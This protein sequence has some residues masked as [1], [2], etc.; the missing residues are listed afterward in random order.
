VDTNPALVTAAEL[1]QIRVMAGLSVPDASE[2]VG[3]SRTTWWRWEKQGVTVPEKLT[4]VIR[5]LT[6]GR[7]TRQAIE[8]VT[9]I[10]IPIYNLAGTATSCK[11]FVLENITGQIG[12]DRIFIQSHLKADPDALV[13]MTIDGDSME[14]TVRSGEVAIL[15]RTTLAS[16]IV[17]GV[18]L[19]RLEGAILCRVPRCF[20]WVTG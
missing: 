11:D 20:R 6:A 3:V 16:R 13:A 4:R 12:L 2:A 5:E 15:G 17:D 7:G 1:L 14:P 9:T 18:Y 19:L 8:D 10:Q